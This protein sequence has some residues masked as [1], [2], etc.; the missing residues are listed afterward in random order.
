MAAPLVNL[1]FGGGSISWEVM[2]LGGSLCVCVFLRYP[3][4]ILA[5]FVSFARLPLCGDGYVTKGSTLLTE[6]SERQRFVH[7]CLAWLLHVG[8]WP[9]TF[10]CLG[11][12]IVHP[13]RTLDAEEHVTLISKRKLT[14]AWV[15]LLAFQAP[16]PFNTSGTRFQL[17]HVGATVHP[18]HTG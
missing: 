14:R 7:R 9:N 16:P 2:C 10:H 3:S 8:R 17:F 6:V 15:I 1:K 12:S 18:F 4:K 5:V 13:K 11:C